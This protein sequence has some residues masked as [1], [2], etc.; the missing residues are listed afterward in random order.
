MKL[1]PPPCRAYSTAIW[2]TAKQAGRSLPSTRWIG[3]G[4][5]IAKALQHHALDVLCLSAL[6]QLNE[7]LDPAFEGGIK[8]WIMSLIS[9]DGVEQPITI[10]DDDHYVTIVKNTRVHITHYKFVRGFVP[11]QEERSFQLVR[12]RVTDTHEQV[13]IINCD[14]PASETTGLSATG[15]M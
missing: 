4:K 9:D 8:T 2:A 15:R 6:G 7:S 13:C 10:Y 12:V 1:G 5:G 11:D 3:I 14:A